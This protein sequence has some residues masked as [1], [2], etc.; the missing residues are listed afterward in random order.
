MKTKF[1]YIAL[2]FAGVV[3]ANFASAQSASFY[4]DSSYSPTKESQAY[5]AIRYEG[6][7]SIWFV[8][9]SYWNGLGGSAQ[10]SILT[11]ITKLSNEFDSAI[12]PRLRALFGSENTPG[13]DN[14]PK[15]TILVLK[16]I[17]EAGGYF[18]EQDGL[19]R[20]KIVNSNEREMIFLNAL[21]LVNSRAKAFLA[22]EFQH[23]ITFNQKFIQYGMQE[24]V[25]L[26]ELRSEIA[27][28][29]LGYD[30][31]Q[32][33]GGSNLEA[34]SKAFLKSPSDALL[35]WE[36]EPG[37]Y[38]TVNLFGQYILDHYG[39]SVIAATIANNK[40]GA[41]SFN[42]ALLFFGFK[43][44]FVEVFR[45]WTLA[46][47]IN[48]CLPEA[49]R[50]YCYKNPSLGY[51]DFHIQFNTVESSG[52]Q[53]TSE[54]LTKDWNADWLR[55]EKKLEQVRPDEHILMVQFYGPMGSDFRVPY[56]TYGADSATILG[57]NEIALIDG[58]GTFFVEDFG[59]KVPKVVIIPYNQQQ[60]IGTNGNAQAVKYTFNASTITEATKV[61]YFTPVISV[62][63]DAKPLALPDL[64]DGSLIRA[65]GDYK[66]YIVK[67]GYRRWIQSA[68]IFNFYGHLG[69]EVVNILSASTVALYKDASLVRAEGD[70]KVYEINGD[71][72]RH[73]LDI[74]AEQFS[75]S[76]RLW[77][78]V[79][80]ISKI[81]L[82]W[83]KEGPAIK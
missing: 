28:T 25:W 12:Y 82:L 5:A 16:M 74:S 15:V 59:Y 57:I 11:E 66:V 38:A 17:E 42:E 20:E 6:A 35:D 63:S 36:N 81:E 68:D 47:L 51:N 27:S 60:K 32:S 19:S 52:K 83:Y 55:L 71:G 64:P 30:N 9:D 21:H 41:A 18:R 73:W 78:M 80:T 54:S 76:G 34:R 79:Y 33:Y 69:F 24:E 46:A 1:V 45:N 77:D 23:L 72:T 61:T 70:Y 2:I 37:D 48:D 75:A 44:D 53:I 10:A 43:E 4:I 26:N 14:N 56:V 7:H 29:I 67:G 3:F 50:M 58:V 22:H 62:I 31:P 39:R 65:E 13:V 8:E 40:T 49:Q